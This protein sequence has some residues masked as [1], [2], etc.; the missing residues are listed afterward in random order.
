MPTSHL[1][2]LYKFA[3]FQNLAARVIPSI[4]EAD[5]HAYNIRCSYLWKLPY[6]EPI[7]PLGVSY[8]LVLFYLPESRFWSSDTEVVF[9]LPYVQWWS[10]KF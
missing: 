7:L 4:S 3:E 10:C 2:I 1:F 5:I 8:S 6:M 9:Y